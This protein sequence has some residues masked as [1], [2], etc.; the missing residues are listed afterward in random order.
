MCGL[1]A[2][3]TMCVGRIFGLLHSYIQT[4]GMVVKI[5]DPDVGAS[6]VGGSPT[7]LASFV[8]VLN[9]LHEQE[10]CLHTIS[11]YHV[12]FSHCC[13]PKI[14]GVTSAIISADFHLRRLHSRDCLRIL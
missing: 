9:V 12:T 10:M 13:M 14:N 5:V 2:T 8:S 7:L 6:R 4:C 1:R 3:V 11:V